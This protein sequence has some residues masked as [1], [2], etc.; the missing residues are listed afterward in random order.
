MTDVRLDKDTPLR[1]AL[2]NVGLW[3]LS[4][5]F[6]I[7]LVSQLLHDTAVFKVSMIETLSNEIGFALLIA[8]ILVLTT[9]KRSRLEF[10]RLMEG[11]ITTLDKTIARDLAEVYGTMHLAKFLEDV[12]RSSGL[13]EIT[14]ISVQIYDKYITGLRTIQGG[15]F[16]LDDMG[17]VSSIE[18]TAD[19]VRSDLNT[20]WQSLLR[21][22]KSYDQIASTSPQ[23]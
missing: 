19:N 7:L 9:E 2:Q 18:V 22:A 17:G 12:Q 1:S 8:A 20:V 11:H 10:N 21:D 23:S 16:H 15:G 6:F 14:R 5:G 13:G 3:A 4:C